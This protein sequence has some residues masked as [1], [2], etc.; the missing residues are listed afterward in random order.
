MTPAD[1]A[2]KRAEIV[3]EALSWERTPY[4]PHA[5]MKGIGTD[6]AMFP[7]ACYFACNLVPEL[8]PEYT[9]DWMLHRDEEQYLAWVTPYAREIT[10]D[11]LG[12]GDFCIWKFGRVYSH[13]AIVIEP[14]EVIHALIRCGVVRGNIDRDVDLVSRPVRFFTLF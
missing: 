8:K 6:C 11:E 13:G 5:A 3:A 12:P 4:H 10:R 2:A 7:A 14:P 1:E 9:Q